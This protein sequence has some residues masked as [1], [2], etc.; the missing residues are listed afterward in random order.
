ME[1]DQSFV[2]NTVQ[3]LRRIDNMF[4]P[5]C[6]KEDV[7]VL[8]RF[9][10]MMDKLKTKVKQSGLVLFNCKCRAGCSGVGCGGITM[11]QRKVPLVLD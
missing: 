2:D 7:Y 3:W 1:S 6:N 5:D 4:P 10:T 9:Y 11:G 8:L